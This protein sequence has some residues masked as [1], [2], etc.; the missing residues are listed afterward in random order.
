MRKLLDCT[1]A[2]IANIGFDIL[3]HPPG[4]GRARQA[5]HLDAALVLEPQRLGTVGQ[6]DTA[7]IRA[8][9]CHRDGS[10]KQRAVDRAHG[11]TMRAQPQ[12]MRAN[13]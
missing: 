3:D 1:H 6:P 11:R 13:R 7:D 10:V 12:H 5:D 4:A 8:A 2:I 9:R